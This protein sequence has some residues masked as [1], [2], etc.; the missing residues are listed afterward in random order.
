ML[1][2]LSSVLVLGVKGSAV[3][4]AT[5]LSTQGGDSSGGLRVLE[6]DNS[7]FL[8]LLFSFLCLFSPF[9]RPLTTTFAHITNMSTQLIVEPWETAITDEDRSYLE[10]SH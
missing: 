5:G 4:L 1:M 3:R 8:T 7:F 2:I 6:A 10:V 9:D